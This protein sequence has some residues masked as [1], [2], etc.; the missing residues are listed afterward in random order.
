MPSF[1]GVRS[2]NP[3]SRA[4]TSGFRLRLF[5]APRNDGE[6]DSPITVIIAAAIVEAVA[7]VMVPIVMRHAE[8]ALD[9]AHGAADPGANC[10][11]DNSAHGTGDPVAFVGTL[12]STAHDA[13]AVAWLRS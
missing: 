1:R 6:K 12:L 5:E 7:V 13:L 10:A 3:E 2:T 11:S 4:T 9:R 8:H